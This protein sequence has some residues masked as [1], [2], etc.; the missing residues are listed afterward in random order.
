MKTSHETDGRADRPTNGKPK[1]LPGFF[2][3]LIERFN[4]ILISEAFFQPRP[5]ATPLFDF[6]IFYVLYTL[7][8]KVMGPPNNNLS[9]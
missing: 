7:G 2:S 4:V 1:R 6:L 3:D 8:Q 9:S 5:L